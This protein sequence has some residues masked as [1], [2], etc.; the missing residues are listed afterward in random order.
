MI[1]GLHAR[2]IFSF[3]RKFQTVFQID[4]AIFYSYQQR[5]QVPVGLFPC[6]QLVLSIK[7]KITILI[8]MA[9]RYAVISHCCYCCFFV[10]S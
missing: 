6:Q 8:G 3:V 7:K 4:C 5:I 10:I 2:T 9:I 1:A